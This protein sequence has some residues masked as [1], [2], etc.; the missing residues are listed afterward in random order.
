MYLDLSFSMCAGGVRGGRQPWHHHLPPGV[1]GPRGSDRAPRWYRTP[2]HARPSAGVQGP[3]AAL[4]S[5]ALDSRLSLAERLR[6]ADGCAWL[7]WSS[8]RP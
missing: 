8:L 7:L 4:A 5:E 2:V 6:V 1:A 3:I